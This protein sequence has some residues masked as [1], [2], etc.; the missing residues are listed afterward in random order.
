MSTKTTWPNPGSDAAVQQ[1]CTCPVFDNAKGRGNGRGEFWI[2][3]DCP[4]HVITMQE[5]ADG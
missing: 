1:G 2:N 4:V 5:Q 3:G